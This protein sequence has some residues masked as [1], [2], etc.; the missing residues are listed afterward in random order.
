MKIPGTTTTRLH[1]LLA[2]LCATALSTQG[3]LAASLVLAVVAARTWARHHLEAGVRL[4]AV[5]PGTTPTRTRLTRR[6]HAGPRTPDA[7]PTPERRA[8]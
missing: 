1:L 6:T 4:P 3:W 2:A 5:V 8:A 7:S